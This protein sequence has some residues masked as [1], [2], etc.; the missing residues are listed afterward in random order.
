MSTAK[1][2]FLTLSAGPVWVNRPLL[3]ADRS[4]AFSSHM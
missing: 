3:T 4:K 1:T 2:D